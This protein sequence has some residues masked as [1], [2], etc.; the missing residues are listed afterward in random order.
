[1]FNKW[2]ILRIARGFVY[3]EKKQK[4]CDRKIP[5]W[6][7]NGLLV[8][9]KCE[10][11]LNFSFITSKCPLSSFRVTIGF[12][13]S[14]SFSY[15][16]LPSPLP[17]GQEAE[18]SG[19]LKEMIPLSRTLSLSLPLSRPLPLFRSL[20]LSQPLPLSHSLSITKPLVHF[21]YLH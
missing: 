7:E 20:S 5:V 3:S 14:V 9:V 11:G 6:G 17:A 12:P 15:P 10:T 21:D 18:R 13:V 19:Q 8:L 4:C 2:T 16:S 1:M